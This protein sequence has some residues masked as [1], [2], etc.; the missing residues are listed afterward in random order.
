MVGQLIRL[1][2]LR[3]GREVHFVL[4]NGLPEVQLTLFARSLFEFLS[5]KTIQRYLP[6]LL[7]FARWSI[8]QCGKS[9]PDPSEARGQIR[10]FLVA[11]ARCLVAPVGVNRPDHHVVVKRTTNTRLDVF[12]ILV[13]LKHFYS[14]SASSACQTR[15]NPMLIDA[16]QAPGYRRPKKYSV[17]QWGQSAWAS[18]LADP[19]VPAEN[20]FRFHPGEWQPTGGAPKN[21]PIR[22]NSAAIEIGASLRDQIVLR[23]LFEGGARVSEVCSLTIRDW[24]STR[25]MNGA[26]SKDK[27]SHGRRRKTIRWSPDTTKLLRRYFASE[28]RAYSAAPPT[29]SELE[30]KFR[31]CN[32]ETWMDEP[33]FLTRRRTSVSSDFFRKYIW[34]RSVQRTGMEI[35]PHA[36][37]HWFVTAAMER[38][39]VESPDPEAAKRTKRALSNYVGWKTKDRMIST[40]DN[41]PESPLLQERIRAVHEQISQGD[42]QPASNTSERK[43]DSAQTVESDE[44]RWLIG[45]LGEEEDDAGHKK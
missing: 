26:R 43:A 45:E 23:I 3:A 34:R 36:A 2:G 27:G 32:A 37:R 12:G 25:F 28:R 20:F 4:S 29:I 44:Y 15:V 42:K 8:A 30:N 40:Y 39:D 21:A 35:T 5:E 16:V 9:M 11:E 7:N 38:I 13:V 41:R 1:E 22:M 18:Y 24:W 31:R 14:W 19:R 6:A 10:A 33:L 17:E